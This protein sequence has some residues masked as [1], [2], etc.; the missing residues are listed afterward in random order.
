M[1]TDDSLSADLVSGDTNPVT[2]N[3]IIKSR[4]WS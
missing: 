4:N 1:P 2:K 3:G